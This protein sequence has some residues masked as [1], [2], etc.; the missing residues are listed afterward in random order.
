MELLSLVVDVMQYISE[1]TNNLQCQGFPT[2]NHVI[3][4]VDSLKNALLQAR[5]ENAAINALHECFLTSLE[6]R[7][8]YT[9][10]TCAMSAHF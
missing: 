8:E 10:Y 7:F 3:P 5:R 6:R 1:A 4:I 9:V 2:L